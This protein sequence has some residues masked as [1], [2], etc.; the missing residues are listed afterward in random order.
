MR[1]NPQKTVEKVGANE[2]KKGRKPS[3][4]PKTPENPQKPPFVV[5]RLKKFPVTNQKSGLR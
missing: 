5:V 4:T 1:K 2:P 3:K